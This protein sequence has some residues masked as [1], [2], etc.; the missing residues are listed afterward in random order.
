[1]KLSIYPG[2]DMFYSGPGSQASFRED[3]KGVFG[4]ADHPRR[5]GDA[6]TDPPPGRSPIEGEV[7]RSAAKRRRGFKP[8]PWAAANSAWLSPRVADSPRWSAPLT[9]YESVRDRATIAR[10]AGA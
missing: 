4:P 7:S 9:A 6:T 2:G 8:T 3:V 1:M 5:P 10:L